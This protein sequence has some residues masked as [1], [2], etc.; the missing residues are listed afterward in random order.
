MSYDRAITVFSPDGHLLQV[1]YS[2][3]VSVFFIFWFC[4]YW[5]WLWWRV[6]GSAL[7]GDL[8]ARPTVSLFFYSHEDVI[9]F[10][11]LFL[12]IRLLRVRTG[13]SPWKHSGWH[14]RKRLRRSGCGKTSHCQV[15]FV[16]ARGTTGSTVLEQIRSENL[17]F[18][19]LMNMP[20]HTLF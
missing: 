16:A 2:M 3:E 19:G 1:E 6:A 8:P 15:R 12:L 13:R 9:S 11:F 17:V 18:V 20:S 10:L 7:D 4:C 5:R 14:S